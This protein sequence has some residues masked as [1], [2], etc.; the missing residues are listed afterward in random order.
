[1]SRVNGR[2]VELKS[3]KDISKELLG[4][5]LNSYHRK[6]NLESIEEN[7]KMQDGILDGLLS[8]IDNNHITKT[9]SSNYIS[10]NGSG[11]GVAIID[12]MVGDTLVNVATGNF[13]V[14]GS[15]V[16]AINQSENSIEV[17]LTQAGSMVT[18]KK[19]M[20]KNNTTY[21][22][23]CEIN[24]N[25]P[26]IYYSYKNDSRFVEGYIIDSRNYPNGYTKIVKTLTTTSDCNGVVIGYH[27][28]APIGNYLNVKNLIL[29]EGDY[30][31]KPI[32]SKVFAGLKS[33]FEDAIVTQAQIDAGTELV[34]NLGKYK[35]NAK[36]VGKNLA[37]E[38]AY[39][40][41]IQYQVCCKAKANL[42]PNTQYT[43]SLIVPTGEQ[44]VTETS[45]FTTR[46]RI[47][48]NDS[49]QTVTVTTLPNI[50]PDSL[51]YYKIFFNETG[52]TSSGKATNLQ[53]VEGAS[54]TPYEPYKE[55]S[56]P[57]Y[58]NSPLLKGDEIKI[59]DDKLGV[60]RNMAKIVLNG[61][62]NEIWYNYTNFITD[63]FYS[64]YITSIIDNKQYA[65]SIL[66]DKLPT[67]NQ[68]STRPFITSLEKIAIGFDDNV[69]TTKNVTGLRAYLQANPMT[70]AYQLTEPY[71]EPSM[72]ELPQWILKSF[73]SSTL[74]IETNIV[75]TTTVRYPLKNQPL[76]TLSAITEENNF[77][78]NTIT[79]DIIPYMMNLDMAI[80][81]AEMSL[82][83]NNIETM[84]LAKNSPMTFNI[85]K[86]NDSNILMSDITRM[87]VDDLSTMQERTY[88]MLERLIKTMVVEKEE[89]LER[90]DVYEE[91]KRISEEQA[92]EL[93]LLVEEYYN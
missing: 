13:G 71:F 90:I 76:S 81:E 52:T 38:T 62:S 18:F 86:E 65:K 60:M 66:C 15:G 40:A 91:A 93:R 73:E 44:F 36:V 79:N 88:A 28:N 72:Q 37:K 39:P 46:Q 53:I 85:T 48:G 92:Q 55:H 35:V 12:N 78:N 31:N 59:Q 67:D 23:I 64:A 16:H 41:S 82:D 17:T 32:P 8:Q 9:E 3:L 6:T 4:G 83:N 69:L 54:V 10:L 1:M 89:M 42:L 43:L 2:E 21:T 75:P 77:T 11:S 29:L 14:S 80:L 19:A 84:E 51:G 27:G 7:S 26:L 34:E 49:M 45:T 87:E 70:V 58:F 30:T 56:F 57:I 68:N 5:T 24:T 22:L 20:L 63:N 47:T 33:S 50:S 74:Y 25:L 61:S